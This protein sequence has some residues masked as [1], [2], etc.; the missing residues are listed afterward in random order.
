M[1]SERFNRETAPQMAD[2]AGAD[3]QRQHA[4]VGR[5]GEQCGRSWRP[6][7]V[8]AERREGRAPHRRVSPAKRR[9][10][11]R[12]LPDLARSTLRA[13]DQRGDNIYRSNTTPT[14]WVEC[15]N[16]R[17]EAS[18]VGPEHIAVMLILTLSSATTVAEARLLEQRGVLARSSRRAP[19]PGPSRHVHRRRHEYA[20]RTVLAPAASPIARRL[21]PESQQT[22]SPSS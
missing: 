2:S 3:G 5:G 17:A 11:Q 18:D 15:P 22:F 12:Q 16:R 1:V 20:A 14:V 19:R 10:S 9:Q 13:R 7:H 4:G 21:P 8:G 6:R